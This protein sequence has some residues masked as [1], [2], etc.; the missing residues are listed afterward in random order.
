MRSM[1]NTDEEQTMVQ[2]VTS[3]K[4]VPEVNNAIYRKRNIG[5]F[6]LYAQPRLRRKNQR[7]IVAETCSP[8]IRSISS[9]TKQIAEHKTCDV[10]KYFNPIITNDQCGEPE[11]DCFDIS[12]RF[13]NRG[14]F[15]WM[16]IEDGEFDTCTDKCVGFHDDTLN[17][18]K[19][20]YLCD[21]KLDDETPQFDSNKNYV[22]F[23]IG[24]VRSR[25]NVWHD[26]NNVYT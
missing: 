26:N 20:L 13:L 4:M 18:G 17:G 16:K 5:G 3:L 9:P 21:I 12:D 11:R 15:N 7:K 10:E 25:D 19:P 23:T 8:R 2:A 14:E 6:N 22:G 24:A 1:K